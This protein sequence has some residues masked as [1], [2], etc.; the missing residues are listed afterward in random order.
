MAWNDADE[1]IVAA[2][3]Q[4]YIAPV[5]TTL[6]TT[7]DG[8]LNA[9]F[10]G[11]GFITEDGATI[12]HTP[13][14]QEFGAWQSRQPVRREK[15][16]GDWAIAFALEQWN[17]VSIPLAFG[18]GTVVSDGGSGFRFDLPS[19]TDALPEYSIVIDA[20]DGSVEHRWV[21]ERGNVTDA[22]ET[23]YQAS[24]L[25][26]LPITFKVLAPSAGGSP[27]RYLTTAAGFAAG[28]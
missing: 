23:N 17:E 9:A 28:S 3:G 2:S 27:G 14:V 4:V 8:T 20:I 15:V 19:D 7:A 10:N 12:T 1:L 11:L 16:K 18:G 24:A 6:P 13:E 21:Y 26:L 25:A 22:V 5:G